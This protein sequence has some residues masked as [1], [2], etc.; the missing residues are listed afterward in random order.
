MLLA[1]LDL[2]TDDDDIII[3]LTAATGKLPAS[4]FAIEVRLLNSYVSTTK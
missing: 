3:N 4:I 2:C 1:L